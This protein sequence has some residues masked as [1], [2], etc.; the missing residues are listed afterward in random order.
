MKR[1]LLP[2]ILLLSA[3]CLGASLAIVKAVESKAVESKA[4][5][6]ATYHLTV[7]AGVWN[8][9][10]ALTYIHAFI[11]DTESEAWYGSADHNQSGV[12]SFDIDVQYTY[13][14]IVRINP[15]NPGETYWKR[16]WNQ[17]QNIPVAHTLN[18]VHIKTLDGDYCQYDY[19]Y[20]RT[21]TAGTTFYVDA[22]ANQNMWEDESAQT[23][24]DIVAD[25]VHHV[26]TL[27]KYK[28]LQFTAMYACFYSMTFAADIEADL[29]I[30]VRGVNF[31]PENWAAT[32][33][34]QTDD[35]T[36][37]SLT[38]SQSAIALGA[39]D[40]K[41]VAYT[42]QTKADDF[43]ANA[44]GK[45]FLSLDVCKDEGGMKSGASALVGKDGRAH[46]TYDNMC[47]CLADS[48]YIKNISNDGFNAINQA[49]L[50]YDTIMYKNSASYTNWMQRAPLQAP[51][52]AFYEP[53]NVQNDSS[54]LLIA[55]ISGV[56]FV[57]IAGYTLLKARRK[58]Q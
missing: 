2:A 33:K 53:V 14:N 23:Y 39:I 43:V 32:C 16:K 57:S 54:L 15:T 28:P 36:F 49:M 46:Q 35:I 31:D 11:P 45:Y 8:G 3:S 52:G 5:E 34:Q 19:Y 17:T 9:D 13:M 18:R 4:D 26:Y 6:P 51:A 55:S 29:I 37:T 12:Y 30:V 48:N 47:E 20:R 1:R 7:D 10:G 58:E 42:L 38:A 21:I 22:T 24:L 27:S 50:R 41:K 56:A 44:Y 40:G 25:D